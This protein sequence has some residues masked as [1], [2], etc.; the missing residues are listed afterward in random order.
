M[1]RLKRGVTPRD[2][3]TPS[4]GA[5]S[6]GSC[7]KQRPQKREG[8][9]KAGATNA[10]AALRASVE[11]T[12]A[13]QHRYAERAGLPCAMVLRLIARSP[14]G[15]GLFAPVTR[16]S[17]CK[18]DPGIGGSGPHAFAVRPC[19]ARPAGQSVHRIPHSTFVTIA[20][21]PSQRRRDGSGHTPDLHFW[22]S[23]IFL[24]VRLDVISKNQTSGKSAPWTP[25][26]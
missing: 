19:T 12:Q 17:S 23:E 26:R 16:R 9:G 11:S 7:Q 25:E 21:R 5:F 6:P 13:S 22:K 20:K 15:A 2:A 1:P 8:A 3:A 10:P 14:R 4:R 18:L 24:S